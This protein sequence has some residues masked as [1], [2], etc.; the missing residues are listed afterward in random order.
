MC[1]PE[2]LTACRTAQMPDAERLARV[3]RAQQED[4]NATL[5]KP[6][7]LVFFSDAVEHVCRIARLLRQPRGSALLVGASG[8]GK[9]TLTRFAAWLGGFRCCQPNIRRGYSPADFRQ[10][11]KVPSDLHG[12]RT[13]CLCRPQASGCAWSSTAWCRAPG[14]V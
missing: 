2:R 3:L 1:A 13:T 11:L 7:S 10:E 5:P 8:S 4:Y 9:Q 6:L 14:P 12:A